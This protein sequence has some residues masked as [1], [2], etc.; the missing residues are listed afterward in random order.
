MTDTT[1]KT[2]AAAFGRLKLPF[3]AEPNGLGYSAELEI[4]G[5]VYQMYIDVFPDV[6]GVSVLTYLPHNLA[7]ADT[8]DLIEY[9]ARANVRLGGGYFDVILDQANTV[10][11]CV[12]LDHEGVALDDLV[13]AEMIRL[14]G[15]QMHEHAPA[16]LAVWEGKLAPEDATDMNSGDLEVPSGTGLPAPACSECGHAVRPR[17]RFC[18]QC[19]ANLLPD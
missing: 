18:T 13:L 7:D 1:K 11:C 5:N 4:D 17:A 3:V 10:R 16:F 9:A 19:G 6:P 15:R 12:A 2:V 14:S 8:A